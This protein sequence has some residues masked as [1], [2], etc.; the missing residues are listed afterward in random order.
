M[1]NQPFSL[2]I[3]PP[4]THLESCSILP[5][6]D[7]AL[8]LQPHDLWIVY[9]MPQKCHC[10]RVIGGRGRSTCMTRAEIT[11][12]IRCTCLHE[13]LIF[14]FPT[15][16]GM[17][18]KCDKVRRRSRGPCPSC[19]DKFLLRI[20]NPVDNWQ[21]PDKTPGCTECDK[22]NSKVTKLLSLLPQN[23]N[24]YRGPG[25]LDPD[26]EEYPPWAYNSKWV[27]FELNEILRSEVSH[28]EDPIVG[29]GIQLSWRQ[30]KEELDSHGLR[31]LENSL[32]HREI[33]SDLKIRFTRTCEFPNV[34]ELTTTEQFLSLRQASRSRSLS[35][36]SGEDGDAEEV[37]ST[38]FGD[39]PMDESWAT[40]DYP[41]VSPYVSEY[42]YFPCVAPN[43]NT[44][45][46]SPE[47][48]EEISPGELK[49]PH[50]SDHENKAQFINQNDL[51]I[52]V[53]N[54]EVIQQPSS[55]EEQLF[56]RRQKSFELKES[57]S[58]EKEIPPLMALSVARPIDFR[59][60]VR[61]PWFSARGL[62]INCGRSGHF[63]KDCPSP[64]YTGP[65]CPRCWRPGFGL[66]NC[67]YCIDFVFPF[68]LVCSTF[69]LIRLG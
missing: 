21:M 40:D 50:E 63:Q 11:P 15:I 46:S 52:V 12:G 45:W 36:F 6:P 28:L 49:R 2:A 14:E 65:R 4:S 20:V 68:F 42:S 55:A 37:M 10:T 67:K 34:Q 16:G 32:R 47:M 24:P 44:D 60:P 26:A 33:S 8:D 31:E 48:F 41:S 30:R 62:C 5:A 25:I 1:D 56:T 39:E 53:P 59:K 9:L 29:E 38:D 69:G 51:V 35:V 7:D 64:K 54:A 13:K 66:G 19:M 27:W 22:F 18:V 3:D 43:Y 17:L 57:R 61:S 23:V 58:F